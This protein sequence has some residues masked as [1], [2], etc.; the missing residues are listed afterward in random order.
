[1][2]FSISNQH[3]NNF[4]HF[5]KLGDFHISTDA[6]WKEL[7]HNDHYLLY[8]GYADDDKLEELVNTI[9]N[10]TE[11]TLLGNFC[12]LDFNTDTG[13]LQIKTDRYRGFPI[14]VSS[15]NEITN[16]VDLGYTVWSDSLIEINADFTINETKFN[17]IGSID[18]QP[19]TLEEALV[20]ID[21]LLVTKTKNFLSHTD[22]PIKVFLSGGVDSLLVYSYLQRFT[23]DYELVRGNYF[24]YDKFWLMNSGTIQNKF[25]GYS[26]FHH[27]VEPCV[28]TSGAPGDEFMLRSPTTSDLF[29]QFHGESIIRL[30]ETKEWASCLH[31]EYF[32]S[33]KNYKIF[34]EQIIDPSWNT[35]EKLMYNLCNIIVNDWQHWHLGNTVSWTP[36]RDLE[37]FKILLRLPVNAALGQIMNSD[38]SYRLIE[39]NRPGLTKLISDQKNSGNAMKNLV[40]FLF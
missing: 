33:S 21:Q 3:K 2:F 17:I 15:G 28:L 12:V 27:W 37:I 9:V 29:A 35:P 40:D 10:Q 38:V 7:K 34:E 8:K 6:G 4:S 13:T 11:P 25:W 23:D 36:L 14:Y 30:L 32:C 22:L 39:Q 20:N 5:Y 26:Q 31:Y 16:L 18:T 24:D 1:M 19:I